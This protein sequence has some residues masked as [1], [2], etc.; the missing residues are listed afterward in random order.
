[1]IASVPVSADNPSEL[2]LELPPEARS[3]GRAR[4]AL[5]ELA[6]KVGAEVDSVALA[7]SEA[8]GNSVVHAFRGRDDGSGTISVRATARDQ[9]LLVVV[10]DD[11]TGMVPD[12]DSPGLGL[13]ASL[14]SQMASEATFQSSTAGTTVT[15]S[16][17]LQSPSGASGAGSD[18]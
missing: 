7:V 11:G 4:A 12:L 2:S 8:V 14:I 18:G 16:F 15:M 13:G 6:R 3:V 1:M 10:A 9:A 5:T 17:S